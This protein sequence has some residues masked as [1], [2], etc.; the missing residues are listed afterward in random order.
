MDIFEH[1]GW[2]QVALLAEDGQE[3]PA[4]HT[5][6][7]DMFLTRGISVVYQRK[8]PRQASPEDAVKVIIYTTI[9]TADKLC[10]CHIGPVS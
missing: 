9:H 8:M 6:L 3:F 7:E 1:F 10:H 2:G 5:F 4:Y